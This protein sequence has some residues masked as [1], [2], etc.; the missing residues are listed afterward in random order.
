L[1]SG[2]RDEKEVAMEPDNNSKSIDVNDEPS[3]DDFVDTGGI[4]AYGSGKSQYMGV[5]NRI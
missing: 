3:D 4:S 5:W 2:R 1:R